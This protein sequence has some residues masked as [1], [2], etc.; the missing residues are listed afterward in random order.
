MVQDKSKPVRGLRAGTWVRRRGSRALGTVQPCELEFSA[1]RFPV[2][3]DTGLWE[4]CDRSDVEV[5]I[6]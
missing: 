4:V 5:I 1:G 3:Y 6:R 2:R